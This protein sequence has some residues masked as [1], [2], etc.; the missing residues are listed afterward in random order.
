MRK[1]AF[2]FALLVLTIARLAHAELPDGWRR[3]GSDFNPAPSGLGQCI[4]ALE[5]G[6]VTGYDRYSGVCNGRIESHA[7]VRMV[8]P[9]A[10][11]GP[12]D[13]LW[14]S[15]PYRES[16]V[17]RHYF[18]KYLDRDPECTE[19]G[20]W[21]D[22][23]SQGKTINVLRGIACS[24]EAF[25][26][27]L[28]PALF[29][30]LMDEWWSGLGFHNGTDIG[31]SV[32]M[33]L[34]A[35]NRCSGDPAPKLSIE[36][37]GVQADQS[38]CPIVGGSTVDDIRATAGRLV[39]D[40]DFSNVTKQG[41]RK[42]FDA[43]T[44]LAAFYIM[45]ANG[46]QVVLDSE[47][48]ALCDAAPWTFDIMEDIAR[49][50]ADAAMRDFLTST[51]GGPL[52]ENVLPS[53]ANLFELY[54]AAAIG[55]ASIRRTNP[56]EYICRPTDGCWVGAR[57]VIQDAINAT[58]APVT[59]PP[60]DPPE[61]RIVVPVAG[62]VFLAHESNP[63][64]GSGES[65]VLLAAVTSKNSG[66][67]TWEN[68]TLDTEPQPAVSGYGWMATVPLARGRNEIV[69]TALNSAN[70]AATDS[71]L[72][73]VAPKISFA[74]PATAA[75]GSF[76][77]F[78]DHALLSAGIQ[79]RDPIRT[80]R[81]YNETSGATGDVQRTLY[82]WIAN[83][84]LTPGRNSVYY[85]ANS[86]HSQGRQDLVV[87]R[88]TLETVDTQPP[89]LTIAAAAPSKNDSRTGIVV[90]SIV[91]DHSPAGEISARWRNFH[92][93]APQSQGPVNATIYGWV[94]AVPLAAGP[95]TIRVEAWDKAGNK[96]QD[97]VVLHGNRF[98]KGSFDGHPGRFECNTLHAWACDPDSWNQK[99]Q[100][101]IREGGTVWA[102]GTADEEREAGVGTACGNGT[103][104]HGI[105]APMPTGLKNGKTRTLRA[106]ARDAQTHEWKALDGIRTVDCP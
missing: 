69:M 101:Q 83:V 40:A 72:V 23:E 12:I 95:N 60:V 68:R 29:C 36:S 50:E 106:F 51:A 1:P 62:D 96:A 21:M 82:G 97:Q 81:W 13:I 24:A 11:T 42:V 103:R 44:I 48:P 20:Q 49:F 41:V 88:R 10:S 18:R 22:L 34:I 45:N 100:V 90:S 17:T 19:L 35:M 104:R 2:V 98:P 52:P 53:N 87:T 37:L 77:T 38:E 6:T 26:K 54:E 47:F 7:K 76:D 86:D 63:F 94:G 58:L 46:R 73:D 67:V 105:S 74:Y 71:I 93:N 79:S 70:D 65:T 8:K 5:G 66:Q 43:D 28:A 16:A 75:S 89:N 30:Q 56:L 78:D 64:V 15:N 99:L 9:G 55:G 14:E 84:P 33:T 4:G 92:A 39:E 25:D 80:V 61:I 3:L 102:S 32:L 31:A 57:Q 27:G 85:V 91:D 59:H